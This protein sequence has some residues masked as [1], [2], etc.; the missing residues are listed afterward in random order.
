MIGLNRPARLH[1]L[2]SDSSDTVLKR[3]FPDWADRAR[4]PLFATSKELFVDANLKGFF[5]R[6]F[7]DLHGPELATMLDSIGKGL[8]NPWSRLMPLWASQSGRSMQKAA[9][10]IKEI[11]DAEVTQRLRNLDEGREAGDYLTGLIAS[12][13]AE[14][15]VNYHEQFLTYFFAAQINTFPTFAWTLLH[16]LRNPEHLASFEAEVGSNPP[17]VDGIYPIKD[18]PF[19]QAC[20]RET[21]RL[22]NNL[23]TLR[24][25]QN[26][27]R[28]PSG[29]IIPKGFVASSPLTVAMDPELYEDPGKWN[30]RRFLPQAAGEGEDGENK[31]VPRKSYATR[32]RDYEFV[33]FGAGKHACIGEK[34]T[35]S[36]LR[37][38]LWPT[39]VDHYSLQLVGSENGLVEGVGM[40]GV[41]VA[42][43][44][45]ESLGT[46]V[47]M[48]EV[49]IKVTKR[50]VPL[51]LAHHE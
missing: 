40:D 2:A 25:A 22:Y 44:H 12:N 33:Q 15:Y 26:D 20:L 17:D 6:R 38:S 7:A 32:L 42:P 31:N 36:L 4:I 10:T 46:P 5:G 8:V 49:Y 41:G 51:S 39:L 37:G 45:G 19:S 34:M 43:N 29:F 35:H 9:K 48:N 23:I 18:M 3:V 14:G 28:T 24:Y 21:G 30:P 27:I 1:H 11:I 16:L 47:G 13:E 50:E